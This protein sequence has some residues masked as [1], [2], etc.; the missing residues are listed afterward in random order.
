MR[1]TALSCV[2]SVSVIVLISRDAHRISTEAEAA[3]QEGPARPQDTL[4]ATGR[5]PAREA[6]AVLIYSNRTELLA[7]VL[8]LNAAYC[9]EHRYDLVVRAA[10]SHPELHGSWQKLQLV[11]DYAP[12]YTAV[13]LM[14][15]E[16]APRQLML[17][18]AA[19]RRASTSPR[20][21]QLAADSRAFALCTP[22]A[23]A[24]RCSPSRSCASRRP[25]SRARRRPATGRS[26]RRRTTAPAAAATSTLACG[27]H[28][29]RRG[30]WTSWRG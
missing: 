18:P 2:L 8:A 6:V 23:G 10:P 24:A 20:P 9:A 27:S 28:G 1:R 22:C 15:D 14:D 4:H 16:Y 3:R 5:A 17:D 13:L 19:S 29:R 12:R 11:L 26:S 25:S 7:P 30:C 21:A